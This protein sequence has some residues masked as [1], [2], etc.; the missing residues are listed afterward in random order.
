MI[1]THAEQFETLIIEITKIAGLTPVLSLDKKDSTHLWNS[2]GLRPQVEAKV[3][4][5]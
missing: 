1:L 2:F 4:Q 5:P 3:A